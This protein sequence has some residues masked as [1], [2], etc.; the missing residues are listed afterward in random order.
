AAIQAGNKPIFEAKSEVSELKDAIKENTA[1][2]KTASKVLGGG[3]MAAAAT[4]MVEREMA[5]YLLARGNA[6]KFG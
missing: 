3:S 2:T 1:A 4:S 6:M 5:I